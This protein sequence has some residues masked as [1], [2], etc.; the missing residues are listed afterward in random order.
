M[1]NRIL[2]QFLIF[3]VTKKK[4]IGMTKILSLIRGDC[5]DM[6]IKCNVVF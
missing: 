6:R 3:K 2:G 1:F 4:K 5:G